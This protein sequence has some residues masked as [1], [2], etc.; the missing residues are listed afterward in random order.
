MQHKKNG[1][2]YLLPVQSLKDYKFSFQENFVCTLIQE[3]WR[4]G[5]SIVITCEDKKQAI[6]IDKEL[7]V[8]DEESFLP[9]DLCGSKINNSPIVIF[10]AQVCCYG[11]QQRDL[12]INLMKE[13]SHIFSNFDE[14]IDFV[15]A[16]SILKQWARIRYKFYKN[17]GFH[18]SIIDASN[19]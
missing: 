14:I 1:I 15:P 5:K 13:H 18:L 19:L 6:R 2:F 10:W 17:I 11:I 9:H 8:F 4:L 7:W 16:E 12:L 3:Q